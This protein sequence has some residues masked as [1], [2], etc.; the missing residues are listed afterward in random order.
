MASKHKILVIGVGS[1]GE[2]HLRC[3]QQTDRAEVSLCEINPQLRGQIAE[4]YSVEHAYA[5]LDSALAGDHQAA[6]ICT[7]AHLHIPMANQLA[8]RGVHLF[9]EKPLSTSLDGIDVLR[10]KIASRN[11]VVGVA[12]VFRAHP[13]LAE[14]KAAI[15]SGQWGKPVQIVY[16]G[17]QNF[18]TYRPAYREIYYK[19]RKTGGGAIQDSI[20]HMMNAGEWLVGPIDS[21]ACDAA[22]QVLE[23]VSVEDTVHVIARH[24][25]VLG[26]YSQNQ[27]QAPNETTITV[28]CERGTA[29]FEAHRKGWRWQTEPETPWQEKSCDPIE[30]DTLFVNQANAFLDALEGKALVPCTLDEALQTLRVNLAMLETSESHSWKKIAS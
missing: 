7:P 28:V 29:R 17:G 8:Q 30:R 3:F 21:L 27:Y 9:I 18:P 20:T 16:T 24:G 22:H 14:M 13:V 23:G 25:S 6:V 19:D 5:D 15:D 10:E 1:I 2:R 26:S 4:R 11:L 12:Y